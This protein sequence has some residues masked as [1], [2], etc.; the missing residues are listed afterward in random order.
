MG[1]ANAG[2]AFSAGVL[3]PPPLVSCCSTGAPLTAVTRKAVSTARAAAERRDSN[4]GKPPTLRLI[5]EGAR[6]KWQQTRRL[7]TLR[8]VHV[9]HGS[10][11]PPPIQGATEY[12]VSVQPVFQSSDGGHTSQQLYQDYRSTWQSRLDQ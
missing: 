8:R 4:G 6:P 9:H 10:A 12:L 5:G 7:M 2:F 11:L 3:V 1:F